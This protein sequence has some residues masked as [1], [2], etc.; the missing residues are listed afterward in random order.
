[1][2]T[3]N[4]ISDGNQK[5]LT[6]WFKEWG[7]IL[8]AVSSWL[9]LLALIV[10]VAATFVIVAM[11]ITPNDNPNYAVYPYMLLGLLLVVILGVFVDRQN[12]RDSRK[13]EGTLRRTNDNKLVI[14]EKTSKNVLEK[15]P[16][17]VDSK[18]GFKI[19]YAMKDN[20]KKPEYL[21]YKEL[22][23]KLGVTTDGQ[24]GDEL[25]NLI[26]LTNPY[27]NMFVQSDN[28]IYQ[29]GENLEIEFLADSTT[30][31]IEDYLK[32]L[33]NFLKDNEGQQLTEEDKQEQRQKLFLG[34]LGITK[35]YFPVSLSIQILQKELAVTS[36]SKPNLP[37]LLKSLIA[38]T[39]EPIEQ[40]SSF[41][42]SIIWITRMKMLNVKVNGIKGNFTIYRTYKLIETKDKLLLL[43]IQWSPESDSAIEVWNELSGML[44]SF[45]LI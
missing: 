21:E 10:L 18:L 19:Y 32:R 2:A 5:V 39:R 27:G 24:D 31:E 28:I 17:F 13:S 26:L 12:E 8:P 9:K 4:N 37:N 14:E 29:Y 3:D 33:E 1:M 36:M 44:D 34:D 16:N 45:A 6:S 43:Q 7:T 41:D 35:L 22:L 30:Q 38:I 15:N 40:L 23:I 25:I 11:I 42:N 20:W